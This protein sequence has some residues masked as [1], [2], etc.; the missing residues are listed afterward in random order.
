MS[1]N[2]PTAKE[3]RLYRRQF[4]LR[5]L[6]TKWRLRH[7]APG[8]PKDLV[9]TFM[10]PL[11]PKKRTDDW[12]RVQYL[13]NATLRSL[14]N[15]TN[16]HWQALVCCQDVPEMPADPRI[17]HVPFSDARSVTTRT[18]KWAKIREMCEVWKSDYPTDGYHFLLDADDL[19]HPTLVEEILRD[20][21][22]GALMLE[23]GF[24][25]NAR[26]GQ[27]APMPNPLSDHGHM[28]GKFF[29]TCGSSA[30]IRVSPSSGPRPHLITSRYRR[31]YAPQDHFPLFG[32]DV[33]LIKPALGMYVVNHGDNMD[34]EKRKGYRIKYINNNALDAEK[35]ME[36]IKAFKL[37]DYFDDLSRILKK[38]T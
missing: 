6:A 14:T 37:E 24:I 28:A 25:A 10:I 35:R 3:I 2:L 13:L 38:A 19:M 32:Y 36:I 22:G 16:G 20:T 12:N 5:L 9:V 23:H 26:T 15:Q 34:W 11:I 8:P 7:S 30:A 21:R 1:F 27:I 29:S 17:H 33:H 31:H 18:D 4:K